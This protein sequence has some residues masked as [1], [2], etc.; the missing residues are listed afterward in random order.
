MKGYVVNIEKATRENRN[1]RKVLYTANN[2]QL[3]LMSLRP[4]ED[5]GEEVHHLDQ[6]IRIEAGTGKAI[7]DGVEHSIEDD[8]AIVIPAGTRHNII[9]TSKNSEMKLYSI[10]SPPE[11]REGVLHKTKAEA[12]ADDEEFDGRTT[13]QL[14]EPE[15]QAKPGRGLFIQNMSIERRK[16]G[17]T[18]VNV[19]IL[20]LGG[21]GVLR[22][23]GYEKEA[24]ALITALGSRHQ[25]LRI[26]AGILRK[27]VL[28]RHGAEGESNS[29][30]RM[31]CSQQPSVRFRYKNRKA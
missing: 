23:Y 8:Y 31:P 5:I 27:R 1:F 4:G 18:D 30:N 13:E 24:Y 9:N 6:F 3:V 12:M 16:L 26:R 15:E 25:L 29:W 19:S 21:E 14:A 7:L 28:L 17:K 11:H 22:T 10:Y 2:S 20:G